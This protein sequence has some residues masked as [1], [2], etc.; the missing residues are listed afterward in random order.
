LIHT[1]SAQGIHFHIYPSPSNVRADYEEYEVTAKENPYFH[2]HAPV[3]QHELALEMSKYDWGILPF[4]AGQNEQS[5]AKYKYATTLK[6]FNFMEAGLP[7]I[8]SKDIIYQSWILDRYGCGV[9]IDGTHI[10]SL[11]DKITP[12]K[13]SAAVKNLLKARQTL[14]LGQ[15]TGR[16]LAFYDQ[17]LAQKP[18]RRNP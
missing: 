16:L 11:R 9:L 18:F 4:F 10:K 14:S 7:V 3:A 1:L 2:F 12:D 6:L 17:M 15:N 13:R 8:V 5:E